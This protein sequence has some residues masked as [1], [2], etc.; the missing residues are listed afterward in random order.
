MEVFRLQMKRDQ[1]LLLIFKETWTPIGKYRS[2]KYFE[3]KGIY[4]LT[5]LLFSFIYF[6]I[7]IITFIR[8]IM[9]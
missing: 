6:Y 1:F 7:N 5:N 9:S 8:Q 3:I 2:T 4:L